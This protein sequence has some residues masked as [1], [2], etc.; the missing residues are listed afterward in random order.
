MDGCRLQLTPGRMKLFLR[1]PDRDNLG[2]NLSLLKLMKRHV[3]IYGLVGG[4]LMP[5]SSGLSIAS[6]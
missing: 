6:W 1:H 2:A 3:L 4:I 5:S